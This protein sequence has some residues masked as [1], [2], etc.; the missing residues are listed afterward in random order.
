MSSSSET[1]RPRL[2]PFLRGRRVG[3][4]QAPLFRLARPTHLTRSRCPFFAA[5]AAAAAAGG[6]RPP[7]R[8]RARGE[9]LR[10][11]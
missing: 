3:D 8:A 1:R 4:V 6:S 10:H 5:V 2:P 11:L 7:A 9:A